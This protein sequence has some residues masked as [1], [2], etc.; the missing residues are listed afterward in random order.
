M[1]FQAIGFFAADTAP[2]QEALTRLKA[3]YGGTPIDSCDVVVAVGGDG[4]VLQ[5]LHRVMQLGKPVYGLNRGTLGFLTNPYREDGLRE[6]IDGAKPEILHPLRM[7][8]RTID[9]RTE[10]AL[11]INEVSLLRETRLAA[12]IEI[13]IDGIV[14]LN[15][16]ICDGILLATPTGSTAYNLSAHGPIIPIG[17]DILALTPIS[18]FRPRRWRGALLRHTAELRFAINEPDTRSVSAVADH[19]EVRDVTDV[20]VRLDPSISLTILFDRDNNLD[21]RVLQEQFTP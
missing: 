20:K 12:K 13:S 5:A 11:A 15:E 21:E 9:G 18:A 16:L 3:R 17:S 2:A 6:R 19:Y 7:T 10:E 1:S 8:A 4:T 14:R